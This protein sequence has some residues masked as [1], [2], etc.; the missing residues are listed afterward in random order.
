MF[1][2]RLALADP[3][4]SSIVFLI[5]FFSYRLTLRVSY[6]DAVVTGVLM[7][8]AFGTKTSII[9]YWGVPL[10]A[11]LALRPA[12]RLWKN[13]FQ[14]LAVVL[15]TAVGLSS[16]LVVG[17]R[18][19]GYDYLSNS[20]SLAAANRQQLTGEQVGTMF[21]FA[22][23][24]DNAANT[25]SALSVYLGPLVLILGMV[26]IMWLVVRGRYYLFLCLAG[27]VVAMW[28]SRPQEIRYWGVFVALLLL[29]GAVVIA[30]II[31]SK[32]RWL[33]MA[34]LGTILAWGVF[35]WVPF[36]L[37]AAK[38]PARLPLP[39]TDYR[40]YVSSDASGFGLSDIRE[41]LSRYDVKQVIGLLANC[42]GL[43][44]TAQDTLPV[45]CPPLNP[46]GQ[47]IERLTRYLEENRFEDLFVVLEDSPYIPDT[48]PGKLLAVVRRPGDKASLSIFALAPQP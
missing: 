14:W 45:I 23:I 19:R 36:T 43:R 39:D 6:R 30:T 42:Q 48:A 1:Y 9:P 20:F 4:A 27:P 46:N 15:L 12:K 13:Q 8:L 29:C 17:L 41:Y 16:A 33:Q 22:R 26:A 47:D 31:R 32:P 35:Q 25:F 40:Q 28:I 11:A 24:A 7:F 37:I 44:Y 34:A 2:D 21:S 3:L 38:D 10:A 5:I 18:L